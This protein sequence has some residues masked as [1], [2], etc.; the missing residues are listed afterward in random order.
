M[1]LHIVLILLLVVLALAKNDAVFAQ[2]SEKQ[3]DIAVVVHRGANKLAPENTVPSAL[4]ALE[5]GATWVEVDVRCSKDNV[6]YNLHDETLDRTTNGKGPICEMLSAD[7]DK[8]DAGSWFSNE[9]AGLRV[10]RISEMLDS[11]QGKAKVFFDVKRGASIPALIDLVRQKCFTDKSFFW[12]ADPAMLVEFTKL[13][14]E[15]KVKVNAKSVKQLKAWIK[16]CHPS[17][18]ETDVASIT[19]KFRKYCQKHG[20]KIMAAIQG[21]TEETYREAIKARPDMVNLDQ[22]ELFTEVMSKMGIK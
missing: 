7:I 16:V 9:Y 5:H 15:M 8:L 17:Y 22:P 20:I 6:M 1:R 2:A 18:V 12:F 14:P 3:R 11:L 10:P 21:A 19:Q 13:A 4:A